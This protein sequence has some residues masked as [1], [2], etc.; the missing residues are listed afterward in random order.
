MAFHLY[1]M[2]NFEKGVVGKQNT[3]NP[4]LTRILFYDAE[5]TKMASKMAASFE[6]SI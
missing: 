5:T 3:E 1:L 2:S 6:V 4:F